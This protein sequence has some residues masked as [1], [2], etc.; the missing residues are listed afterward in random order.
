MFLNFNCRT[1]EGPAL[2]RLLNSCHN[3][4]LWCLSYNL[5]IL[6]IQSPDLCH[7]IS[8]SLSYNLLVL[9]KAFKV[10]HCAKLTVTQYL[11]MCMDTF[12]YFCCTSGIQ[13]GY[14]W[15]I[16][17]TLLGYFWDTLVILL[18]Y[19]RDS[20]RIFLDNFLHTFRIL[21]GF[22]FF[23]FLCFWIL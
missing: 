12:R 13:F 21:F 9:F 23:L 17:V 5:L 11:G 22:F 3:I 7:T 15:N 19:F 10:F 2:M 16:L 4:T 14:F 20:F 6:V 18:Q 1:Q 8:W